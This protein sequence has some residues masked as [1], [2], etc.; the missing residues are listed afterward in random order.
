MKKI[1]S[2][3]AIF[4]FFALLIATLSSAQTKKYN[5]KKSPQKLPDAKQQDMKP[6]VRGNMMEMMENMETIERLKVTQGLRWANT[7]ADNITI[8][9]TEPFEF[10]FVTSGGQ[11]TLT[12][13]LKVIR[14]HRDITTSQD[15]F[16]ITSP[17]T[18][19]VDEPHRVITGGGDGSTIE[20]ME[21]S[22]RR[23][24]QLVR[25]GVLPRHP[26]PK[27]GDVCPP[28]PS[29]FTVRFSGLGADAFT[30]ETIFAVLEATV[31]D[32]AGKS[33]NKSVNVTLTRPLRWCST[34][35]E[36]QLQKIP[37]NNQRTIKFGVKYG[38]ED[39]KLSI[40]PK[41]PDAFTVFRTENENP[42]CSLTFGIKFLG[43]G[44]NDFPVWETWDT[45]N[46]RVTDSAATPS[47]LSYD[48]PIELTCAAD[49]NTQYCY[50]AVGKQCG[51]RLFP[52]G[53]PIPEEYALF[54]LALQESSCTNGKCMISG[55]S[56]AHDTCCFFHPEG[57][58]CPSDATLWGDRG[59]ESHCK[60]EWDLAQG[61]VIDGLNW[62]RDVNFQ[63]PNCSG[64]VLFK[65][66]C[67]TAGSIVHRNDTQYCCN[68]DTTAGRL[69]CSLLN[70]PA[71]IELKAQKGIS[72]W[73]DCNNLRE[74]R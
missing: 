52:E 40:H 3:L 46:V 23:F 10:R 24:Q 41:K 68:K 56:W 14:N 60:G 59:E 66:Y 9:G 55:G 54:Y 29:V 31:R 30:P 5:Q 45:L 61:R 39:I 17:A 11:G 25:D 4:V 58:M 34:P 22:R 8:Y 18:Q 7:P 26:C 27:S 19:R 33:I 51:S 16:R 36:G 50:G 49:P 71:I 13:E 35:P 74:C 2:S 72:E 70:T 73:V 42:D 47:S 62:K 37:Y 20:E 53:T 48:L 64:I 6:A 69:D 38:I 21:T 65:D 15:Y 32:T 57:Y 43:A 12:F 28:E 1:L 67:A 63:K 44:N